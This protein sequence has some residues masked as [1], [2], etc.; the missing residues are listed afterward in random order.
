MQATTEG[1]TATL[2]IG[3]RDIEFVGPTSLYPG[4]HWNPEQQV[5]EARADKNRTIYFSWHYSRSN[6]Q[7]DWIVTNSIQDAKNDSSAYIDLVRESL[8]HTDI[9]LPTPEATRAPEV[10]HRTEVPNPFS[11]QPSAESVS[12]LGVLRRQFKALP[13]RDSSSKLGEEEEITT[14]KPIE[15]EEPELESKGKDK[16]TSGDQEQ[17]NTGTSTSNQQTQASG[18][19][20]VPSTKKPSA[21]SSSKKPAT[22]SSSKKQPTAAAMTTVDKERKINPPREFKGDHTDIG[23]AE[24]WLLDCQTYLRINDKSYT[25]DIDKVIWATSFLREGPAG[26]WKKAKLQEGLAKTPPD[27]G[28]WT[29]FETDFTKTFISANI[30]SDARQKFFRMKQQ[31]SEPMGTFNARFKGAAQKAKITE[32]TTLQEIYQ[33]AANP[34]IIE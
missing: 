12:T 11:R 23:Q 22:S 16:E 4:S 10:I 27:V 6:K 2:R 32:S 19:P 8:G 5:F 34:A 24:D 13:K 33:M 17:S 15:S 31:P 7:W 26:E 20:P 21:S 18:P 25:K 14:K 9:G 28:T 3:S 29:E 1:T 30:E